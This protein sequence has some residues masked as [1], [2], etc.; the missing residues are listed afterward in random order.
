QMLSALKWW[1]VGSSVGLRRPMVEYVRFYF[2]GMVVNVFGVSTIG[3]DVVRGLYLGGGRHAALALDSVVFDRVSG[4]AI[5]MALGAFALLAF[6]EYR[7]P[8]ALSLALMAGGLAIAVGWW[9]CPRLVR[10]L[11]VQNRFRRQVEHELAPFWR[12]RR[13]LARISALSAIFHLSQVG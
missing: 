1:L 7:L 4:L 2:I 13:L 10:L 6:P 3:G 12:D 8:P 5:L 9:T 11:P